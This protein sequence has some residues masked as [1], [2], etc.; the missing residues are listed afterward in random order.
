[1]KRKK[2]WVIKAFE[3][4]LNENLIHQAG[5]RGIIH[6]LRYSLIRRILFQKT[7]YVCLKITCNLSPQ[8]SLHHKMFSQLVIRQTITIIK[9]SADCTNKKSAQKYAFTKRRRVKIQALRDQHREYLRNFLGAGGEGRSTK[10][11]PHYAIFILATPK[12]NSC[13]QY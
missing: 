12:N 10:L 4:D 2:E 7:N 1:M 9:Q 5:G 3:T 6:Q 13:L 8:N 11:F